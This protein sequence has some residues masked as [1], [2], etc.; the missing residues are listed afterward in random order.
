MP[1]FSYQVFPIISKYALNSM[2]FNRIFL[3]LILEVT[4]VYVV[5]L[6]LS[7]LMMICACILLSS[8][9][10]SGSAWRMCPLL[11]NPKQR[12]KISWCRRKGSSR[13]FAS[14][15]SRSSWWWGRQAQGGCEIR[16]MVTGWFSRDLP[17]FLP[18]N[19]IYIWQN[20]HPHRNW[21]DC[22]F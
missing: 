14:N 20:F 11:T 7:E 19:Q 4:L 8:V 12:R 5:N 6:L 17:T 9:P 16:I 1:A 2:W 15:C 21:Y 3:S 10:N 13:N 18:A 22:D